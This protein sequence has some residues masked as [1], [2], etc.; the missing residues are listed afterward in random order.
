MKFIE[1]KEVKGAKIKLSGRLGGSEMS[2]VE[3]LGKG[4]IPL[5]TLRA[6]VDFAK[7]NAYCTYG[8]IGVKVWIYKGDVFEKNKS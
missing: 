3:W 8:V 4:K 2:R 7:A 5:Q 1:N 6:N